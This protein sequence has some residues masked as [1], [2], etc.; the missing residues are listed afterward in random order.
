M[1]SWVKIIHSS[2]EALSTAAKSLPRG[3]QWMLMAASIVLL[4][5]QFWPR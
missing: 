3:V 2:E 1:D 4:V 5:T